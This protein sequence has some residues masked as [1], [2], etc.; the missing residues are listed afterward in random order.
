ME[1]VQVL[2]TIDDSTEVAYS[3]SA[4]A[5]AGVVSSRYVVCVGNRQH[6]SVECDC[7][8]LSYF[9]TMSDIYFWSYL[10]INSLL[11]GPHSCYMD[12]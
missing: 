8:H 2:Q 5:L 1:K 4:S 6:A 9:C 12:T 10:V 11:S 7:A 3:I